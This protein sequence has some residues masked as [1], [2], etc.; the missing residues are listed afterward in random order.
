[1]NKITNLSG[2]CHMA[3][4]ENILGRKILLLG[5]RHTI[6]GLCDDK[7]PSTIEIHDYLYEITIKY[8]ECID[9]FHETPYMLEHIEHKD[10]NST[11][12]TIRD[13][14]AP[15]DAVRERFKLTKRKKFNF[16]R[17]HYV[18]LRQIKG[19]R[20]L[21]STVPIQS[22]LEMISIQLE[23]EQTLLNVIKE[24]NF[25][26]FIHY[27]K[28]ILYYLI[29][30]FLDKQNS[31]IGRNKLFYFIASIMQLIYNRAVYFEDFYD[32]YHSL[33]EKEYFK[34][35]PQIDKERF[36]EVFY[37]LSVIKLEETIEILLENIELSKHI[38]DEQSLRTFIVENISVTLIILNTICMDLYTLLRMFII[39]DVR[40][41]NRGPI[42]CQTYGKSVNI[43]FNGGFY[44]SL[45][46]F[47]F[48]TNYFNQEPEINEFI[49]GQCIKDFRDPFDVLNNPV[50][51]NILTLRKPIRI[52]TVDKIQRKGKITPNI[53]IEG[54]E[55]EPSTKTPRK[56]I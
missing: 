10:P 51:K 43:I 37:N 38:E 6:E 33:I 15:I 16:A 48:I 7:D 26:P 39:Y 21:Q 34:L 41:L 17:F 40:K 36:L 20:T 32:F 14:G 50:Y 24:I 2:V 25:E 28:N 23:L 47:D 49:I 42:K 19:Y 52:P 35:D 44:H 53:R 31:K 46:Y 4:F 3:Y 30:G 45:F 8:P 11:F 22:P 29:Y 1:M 5:E 55:D 12:E 9:I 18:D 27:F 13:L 54:K 56:F